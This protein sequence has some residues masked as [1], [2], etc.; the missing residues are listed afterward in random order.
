MPP[1]ILSSGRPLYRFAS[2]TQIPAIV[3]T[4]WSMLALVLGIRRSLRTAISADGS[5]SIRAPRRSSPTA[6]SSQAFVLL[7]LV[8]QR[9]CEAAEPSP[10]PPEP[11]LVLRLAPL[12]LA[13][14]RGLG[15]ARVSD[16]PR[17]GIGAVRL[18]LFYG[19]ALR[20]HP[21]RDAADGL[22]S[23]CVDG[24][25]AG[26]QARAAQPAGPG[27][28]QLLLVTGDAAARKG[29]SVTHLIVVVTPADSASIRNRPRPMECRASAMETAWRQSTRTTK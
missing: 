21:A 28:P 27:V 29:W 26:R 23:A 7:P 15:P 6:P 8:R 1:S 9:H 22:G 2:M 16:L 25:R 14:S 18:R 17:L 13:A 5:E 24:F 19:N 20:E 3:T 4:M 11:L 12:M 10:L